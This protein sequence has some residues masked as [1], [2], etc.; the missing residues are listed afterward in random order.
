[1]TDDRQEDEVSY[2]LKEAE[3]MR[4]NDDIRDDDDENLYTTFLSSFG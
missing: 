3:A 1:M 4:P 2:V